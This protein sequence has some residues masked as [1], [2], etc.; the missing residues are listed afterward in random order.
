MHANERKIIVFWLFITSIGGFMATADSLSAKKTFQITQG[1]NLNEWL[2][3]KDLNLIQMDTLVTHEKIFL[4]KRLGFDHVRIPVSEGNLF[5]KDLNYRESMMETFLDR[6]DYCIANNVK[7]IIDL[8][9][10]R[11]HR[12]GVE[13][14][15]LF[16]SE[17][18][19]EHFMKVWGKLQDVLS[20][21]STDSLA[22]ECLNEPAAPKKKHFLWNE[23]LRKWVDF[24]RQK[25]PKR[26]LFI[27]SNRGNQLWTFK[28]LD[29]PRDDLYLVLTFHFYQPSLF[30][31]YKTP[32]SKHAF[33][34]GPVHYPGKTLL[35]E[36]YAQLPETLQYEYKYTQENYNKDFISK[37]IQKVIN[38]AKKYNLQIN[39]G[40]F[41][42]QRT[43][44]DSSRYQ[45]FRDVVDV[46][47]ENNIS[48][49]LWG[50]NGAG[51][52]IWNKNQ[53]LDSL[54][55]LSISERVK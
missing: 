45:W 33:Y 37:E 19:I 25:E 4:L 29:I 40:E 12:F 30:T 14:N 10:T 7:V 46:M 43:V 23:V 22:Y 50:M 35:P 44:T 28:Y 51:F 49:T 13:D 53:K 1:I 6:V 38:V 54:M 9:V 47:N 31:H 2:E 32:W 3:K 16:T 48:Y 17:R 26:F 27:G 34:D 21:Y 55:L 36:E 41:G 39:L 42:C 8:H 18:E 52:G 5:D 11:N 24:I 15:A 20:R